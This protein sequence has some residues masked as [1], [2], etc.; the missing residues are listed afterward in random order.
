MSRKAR[1]MNLI[2]SFKTGQKYMAICPKDKEFA[3]SFPEIRVIAYIKLANKYL[4]PVLAFLFLCQY[5]LNTSLVL[6]IITA[7]FAIS[8]PLQGLFWL[9]KR[10]CSPLPLNLLSYYDDIKQKLV[11]KQVLI[12]N[13]KHN[14]PLNYMAFMQLINLAK[15]HLGKHFDDDQ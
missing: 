2:K 12:N 6:I 13:S 5:Y 8:L 14:E 15:Q 9:G 1:V 11:K 3:T 4:P 7:I 10:A